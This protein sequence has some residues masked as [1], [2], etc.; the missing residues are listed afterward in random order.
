M[1]ISIGPPSYV[2]DNLILFLDA[3]NSASYPGT[4]STV[5]DISNNILHEHIDIQ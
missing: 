2:T 4:G 3:G 1:A 5:F